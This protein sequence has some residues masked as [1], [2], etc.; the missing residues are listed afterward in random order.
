MN[1]PQSVSWYPSTTLK[2]YELKY[3]RAVQKLFCVPDARRNW[4]PYKLT[5]HQIE[6]HRDDVACQRHMA[7]NRVAFKSR[8]TSFTTSSIISNLMSVGVYDTPVIPVVRLNQTRA[9]DLIDDFKKVIRHMPKVIRTKDGRHFP[10]D[11]DAVVMRKVGSIYFPDRE[12]EIRAFPATADAAEV[13]RGLRVVGSAGI[14][15]E[16]FT[17]ETL[18]HTNH[19][20]VEIGCI[21]NKKDVKVWSRNTETG[22]IGLVD[23]NGVIKKPLKERELVYLSLSG[24]GHSVKCTKNHMFFVWDGEMVVERAAGDLKVGDLLVS[25]RKTLLPI[26][27]IKLVRRRC[28]VYD[29]D[30]GGDNHHNYFVGGVG[31][32]VHNCNFM[33]YFRDIYTALRDTD[34]G[35]DYRGFSEFQ[36]N[37]GTTLK[38]TATR[39]KLWLDEQLKKR[40]PHIKFYSWPVFDPERF[41]KEVPPIEQDLTPIVF[42]HSVEKLNEKWLDDLKTFLEEFMC[43]AVD[44]DDQLYPT[45]MIQDA[46]EETVNYALS[47]G[48]FEARLYLFKKKH[49]HLPETVDHYNEMVDQY[50]DDGGLVPPRGFYVAG[51]DIAYVNDFYCHAV[52]RQEENGRYVQKLLH[53]FQDVSVRDP[54]V[55]SQTSLI[56]HL[57]KF[58]TAMFKPTKSR[59]DGKGVGF[60]L[61]SEVQATF[62]GTRTRVEAITKTTAIKGSSKKHRVQLKEYVHTNQVRLLNSRSVSLIED[63]MQYTHYGMWNRK[64]EAE[65]SEEK[66]HG[67]VVIANGL[68]LLPTNWSVTKGKVKPAVSTS[69]TREAS[70]ERKGETPKEVRRTWD[71]MSMRDRLKHYR[72]R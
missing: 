19:G 61:A 60:Q 31:V 17:P 26:K 55:V 43:V 15:D 30:V 68:A 42:W 53:Y 56:E 32:N 38:G 21:E 22:E 50:E 67:D 7:K 28:R 27:G 25:K 40:P 63:E 47:I 34:A 3:L 8:N 69:N 52:F 57:T 39:F 44:A 59:I 5:P 62:S 12:T 72:S 9:N 58:Y 24:R 70:K 64:Y 11:P 48:D 20:Y 66:G 35:V 49:G 2:P 65:S 54:R 16:C 46:S 23:V 6:W 45:D 10:F 33:R 36:L 4:V 51:T 41:D 71:K 37:I 14:I 13:I 1:A 29:L 18:V